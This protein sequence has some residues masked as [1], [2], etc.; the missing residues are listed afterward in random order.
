V[1]AGGIGDVELLRHRCRTLVAD[2]GESW[3]YDSHHTEQRPIRW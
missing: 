2:D 1:D 3:P